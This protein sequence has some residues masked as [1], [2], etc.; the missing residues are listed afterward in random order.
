MT[1]Y[2][3]KDRQQ[4][5]LLLQSLFGYQVERVCTVLQSSVTVSL[6]DKEQV[7]GVST[8]LGLKTCFDKASAIPG[9]SKCHCIESRGNVFVNCRQYSNQELVEGNIFPFYSDDSDSDSSWEETYMYS[10]SQ[11]YSDESDNGK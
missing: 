3:N 1:Q 4:R 10:D 11:S 7:F 6:V 9:I 8:E 2:P 5:K